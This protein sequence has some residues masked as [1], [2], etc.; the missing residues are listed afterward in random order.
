MDTKEKLIIA[1]INLFS[2]KGYE[3]TGVD[4]I[5][6]AVGIK[7]P[8]IYAH[9]NGKEAVLQAVSEYAEKEYLSG[10][11]RGKE[12]AAHICTGEELKEYTKKSVYFTLNN[13]ITCKMRRLTTMEQFRNDNFSE[14]ATRYQIT[15]HKEIFAEIF[16]K[17][18]DVGVLKK[19]NADIYALE[20][21][22]PITL[23]IQLCDRDPGRKEEAMKIIDEHIDEFVRN[24]FIND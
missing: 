24:H 13:E 12:N 7:G 16:S 5:A 6:K 17:M 18:M 3:G 20:Y 15:F 2:T 22:A 11:H 1:A 19:G 8:S 21:I 10:M 23:M 14:H 9:F 4:E